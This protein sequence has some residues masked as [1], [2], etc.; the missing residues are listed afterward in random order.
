MKF[1]KAF[2]IV[3]FISLPVIGCGHGSN[4]GG[5]NC[6]IVGNENGPSFLKV[7]N[8]LSTGLEWSFINSFSFGADMKPGECISFGLDEGSYTVEIN[9]CNISDAVCMMTFGPATRRTFT[10]GNQHTH[11]IMVNNSFF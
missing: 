1:L 11:T 10:L 5:A 4:S 2:T 6:K 7:I 8:N 9:Q 3:V